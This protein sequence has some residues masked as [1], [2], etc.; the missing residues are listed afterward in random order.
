MSVAV[1][2]L[3]AGRG[4]RFGGGEHKLLTVVRGRRIV[5]WSLDA[6][7]ASNLGPVSIVTGDVPLDVDA[8]RIEIL[9]NPD[10]AEGIATS[11]QVA[12]R[13]ATELG[14]ESLVVGLADQPCVTPDAWASVGTAPGPIVVAT[15][16]GKRGNPVKLHAETWRLTPT[17]GDE[18][19]RVLLAS[20]PHLVTEVACEGSPIDLDR[21]D[22]LAAV[23]E[24]L[25]RHRR[26][27]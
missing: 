17:T 27:H 18:G 1:V 4:S 24:C 21:T 13:R 8:E 6:A 20:H 5:D 7:L 16:D 9:H 22:D 12:I 3:A 11:L 23:D 14:S 26:S 2:L 25:A 15:Y 19:A 10:W